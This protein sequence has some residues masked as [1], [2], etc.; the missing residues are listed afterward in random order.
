MPR[1][2][3]LP[4]AAV[5]VTALSSVVRAQLPALRDSA[6]AVP[7][8]LA[9]QQGAHGPLS[10][11]ASVGVGTLA[12]G[13]FLWRASLVLDATLGVRAR[14]TSGSALL[15]AA[16]GGVHAPWGNGIACPGG[17]EC[18]GE[19]PVFL[20]LGAL[21]GWEAAPQGPLSVRILAGPALYRAT[22]STY[23]DDDS[24]T[25][26]GAQVRGDLALHT[27]TRLAIMLSARGAYLPDLDGE[28]VGLGTLGLGL[29]FR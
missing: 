25:T 20:S 13:D 3:S 26:A 22:A 19:H 23:G 7:P 15:V 16:S 5:L 4:L 24:I 11:D 6:T 18:T 28:A 17:G 29:R 9:A 1:L 14:E 10:L 21:A 27:T 2:S 12:G 8:A